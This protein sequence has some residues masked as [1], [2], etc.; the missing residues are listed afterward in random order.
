MKHSSEEIP[1]ATS[2]SSSL[3]LKYVASSEG[4][5]FL[6]V[7]NKSASR[8][9]IALVGVDFFEDVSLIGNLYK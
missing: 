4:N 6:T 8:L 5:F 7:N 9:L 1:S 2:S 3:S